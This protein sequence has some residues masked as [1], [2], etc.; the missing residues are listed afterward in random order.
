MEFPEHGL[1]RPQARSCD[2][3]RSR[4]LQTKEEARVI[5]RISAARV[6]LAILL[7]GLVACAAL[8]F[9]AIAQVSASRDA[10]PCVRI[11]VL[12]LFHPH[13]LTVR[14]PAGQALVLAAGEDKIIL[15]KSS[16]LELANVRISGSGV[17]VVAGKHIVRAC[18]I[19]ISGRQKE[20][21]DFNLAV[22][23]KIDRHYYGTLEIEPSAGNL[24]AIVSMDLETAVASVVAAEN[25]LDT[26][27]EALKAQAIA[28][29]SYFVAGR[30]RHHDFD[31][32]DT[33]HCQFLR[34]PPAPGSAAA[35][36]VAATSGL[37]L[38]YDAEPFAAMYT[39][40]CSGRT[41]TPAEVHL[42]SAAYPYFPVEC[43]YCRE[44]PAHWVMRMSA[45]DAAT[46]HNFDEAAR[47]KIV[48][49]LG[50][51]AVPSNDFEKRKERDQVVLQ[52]T[53]YGHGIGLCQAGA[54][55]MA[56]EGADFEK[57]LGH[58]FPNT[59]IVHRLPRDLP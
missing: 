22:P 13:Q 54:K 21:V 45:E 52:G 56:E 32:C 24:V 28:T 19:T 26:P 49:R 35:K 4:K 20:P 48:R 53:G 6:S 44:H 31:F 50:W 9:L 43:K 58:Y 57:I 47:L 14:A 41:R 11:G 34:E 36:A 59:T 1:R 18:R 10:S 40:S 33:T 23:G 2:G 8:R 38:A 7:V 27:L 16:G 39:R 3:S 15:E 55:A 46:L 42:P 51:S 29:R 37:V 17:L 12:G 30:G 5:A 25:A